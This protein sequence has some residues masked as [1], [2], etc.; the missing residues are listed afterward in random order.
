VSDARVPLFLFGT[1]FLHVVLQNVL[2][3]FFFVAQAGQQL[4]AEIKELTEE[5]LLI[6]IS[7]DVCG[8]DAVYMLIVM[9][10]W[11]DRD[12]K[13]QNMLLYC[14]PLGISNVRVTCEIFIIVISSS[15]HS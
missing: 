10:H 13:L 6:C 9:G 12:F 5:R 8:E 7:G 1:L 3:G 2:V 11:V 15:K 14:E 4:A